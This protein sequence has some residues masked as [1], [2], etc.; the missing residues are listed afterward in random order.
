VR[1]LGVLLVVDNAQPV[2]LAEANDERCQS[3]VRDTAAKLSVEDIDGDLA[4]RI[5]LAF[6]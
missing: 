5:S 1:L 6:T 4:K 2:F 3:L